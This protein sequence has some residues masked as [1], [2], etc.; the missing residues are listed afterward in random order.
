MATGETAY[1]TFDGEVQEHQIGTVLGP[2]HSGDHQDEEFVDWSDGS[3]LYS[4]LS[5]EGY[6]V[7]RDATITQ[8][9]VPFSYDY[10]EDGTSSPW[11]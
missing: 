5:W 9:F 11:G 2:V 6:T 1:I 3:V 4:F 10:T 7:Y 8:V